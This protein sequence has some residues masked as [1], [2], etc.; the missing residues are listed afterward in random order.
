MLATRDDW[1][2]APDFHVWVDLSVV[3]P[4]V[5]VSGEIDLL[6]CAPFRDALN[7]AAGHGS[8]EIAVDVRR[9]TFMGSTGIRE[10][11]RA[12]RNLERIEVRSPNPIVRRALEA[13]GLGAGIDV[14]D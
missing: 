10:L 7:E 2:A 12:L 14:V 11:M 4:C 13:A 9:V 3:P 5:G 8:P 1:A 6:T